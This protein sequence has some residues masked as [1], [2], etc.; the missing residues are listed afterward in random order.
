MSK[1]PNTREKSVEKQDTSKS[2]KIPAGDFLFGRV[3]LLK[4]DPDKPENALDVKIKKVT[5][6]AGGKTLIT[7]TKT[8]TLS[9]N[10]ESV[11]EIEERIE[12]N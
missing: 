12:G 11:V 4:D 7:T 8:Y 2:V 1:K 9:N 10:K 6:K 3:D 5:K